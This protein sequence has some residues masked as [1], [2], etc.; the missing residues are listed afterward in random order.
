[1]SDYSPP[2]TEEDAKF[3]NRRDRAIA[4]IR[5]MPAENLTV[6]DIEDVIT[7]LRK[8]RSDLNKHDVGVI[9]KILSTHRMDHHCR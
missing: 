4:K 5:K 1:M 6:G 3:D 8:Y 9:E 7:V 2:Y